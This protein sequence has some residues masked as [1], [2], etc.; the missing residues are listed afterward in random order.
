MIWSIVSKKEMEGCTSPLFPLYEKEIGKENIRLAIVDEDNK[1]DFV[2]KE[3]VVLLRTASKK[4][5]ST[6]RDKGIMSTAEDYSV[7]KMVS[8]KEIMTKI[9]LNSDIPVAAMYNIDDIEEGKSYFVKPKKGSDSKLLDNSVCHSKKDV[10]HQ[11]DAIAK[12]FHQDAIIE[13]YL[14]GEEYTVAC[15]KKKGAIQTLPIEIVTK[16]AVRECEQKMLCDIS[17][18]AFNKLKLRHH[19]RIDFK[20]GIDGIPYIIDVN[21]I[22]S[23]GPSGK[24]AE[25]FLCYGLSYRE[26][27]NSI[28]ASAT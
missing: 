13:D 25:C 2:N 9:L 16:S 11:I 15:Y 14:D 18:R 22:P 26:S 20:K 27:L 10:C 21:L 5:V 1:L 6:I 3:D 17:R 23:I 4:L 28:I 24:W 12:V 19:A 8:N 7:Y